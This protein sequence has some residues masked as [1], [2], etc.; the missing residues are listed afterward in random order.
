ME[1]SRDDEINLIIAEANYGW[2]DIVGDEAKEGL[3]KPILHT[4]EDA[5]APSGAEFYDGDRIPQWNGKYFVATLRGTHLHMI[6]F[7]LESN[8]VISHKELFQDQFGRIRGVQTGPDGFLYMLTSNQDGR[9]TPK[10]ND[11]KILRVVPIDN[12]ET[13]QF[14]IDPNPEDFRESDN[15]A[16]LYAYGGTGLVAMIA[17]FFIVKKW[18]NRN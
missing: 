4:E 13:K 9:G 17:G 7:D 14:V 18:K 3:E 10:L 6:E 5:W 15:S 1:K 2:P 8:S 16:M 12:T 11:D